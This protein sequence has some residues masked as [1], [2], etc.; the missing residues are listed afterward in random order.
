MTAPDTNVKKQAKKHKAPLIGM[1]VA[2]G[3]ALVLLLWLG[4]QYVTVTPDEN[5]DPP[6]AAE[7]PAGLPAE[8]DVSA[9]TEDGTS[10]PQVIEE[11][12]TPSD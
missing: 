8:G 1:A 5:A 3:V 4:S 12:P 6:A 7:E 11:Q 2:G 9:P 10:T